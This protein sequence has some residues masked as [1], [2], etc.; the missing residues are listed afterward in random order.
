V[1]QAI[2]R[3][4]AGPPAVDPAACAL[5]LRPRASW[6]ASRGRQPRIRPP[7][8]SRGRAGSPA[9][10]HGRAHGR[11]PRTLGRSRGRCLDASSGRALGR[12]PRVL[13]PMGSRPVAD[14]LPSVQ[15][16]HTSTSNTP[17]LPFFLCFFRTENPPSPH[18]RRGNHMHWRRQSLG[19]RL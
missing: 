8:A 2:S 16:R 5:V 7:D 6:A 13:L 19:I 4:R 1:G 3:V 14:V 11:Q 10:S 17:V 15:V 9:V 18:Q 12:Q